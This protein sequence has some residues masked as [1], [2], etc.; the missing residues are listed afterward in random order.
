M[1]AHFTVAVA[2]PD[3]PVGSA[4]VKHAR[5]VS[6]PP[7]PVFAYVQGTVP[8]VLVTPVPVVPALGPS[9]TRNVTVRP[10]CVPDSPAIVAVTVCVVWVPSSRVTV[11]GVRSIPYTRTVVQAGPESPTPPPSWPEA[12]T[13]IV[14]APSPRPLT[15]VE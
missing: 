1:S 8:L 3:W 5:I 10:P 6:I 9:A 13:H 15:G 14:C 2:Q 12:V 4:T 11:A 7:A